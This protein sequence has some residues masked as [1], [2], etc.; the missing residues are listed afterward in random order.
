MVSSLLASVDVIEFQTAEAYSSFDLSNVKYNRHKQSRDENLKLME[1][2]RP[3][4]L[5]R[6]ENKKTNTISGI[7]FWIKENNKTLKTVGT[8]NGKMT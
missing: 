7:S 3:N 4:S 8:C 6:S 1:R 5:I 2:I